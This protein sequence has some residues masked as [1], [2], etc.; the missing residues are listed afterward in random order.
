[1]RLGVNRT[2]S[3]T[4]RAGSETLVTGMEVLPFASL[5]WPAGPAF[6]VVVVVVGVVV[7]VVEPVVLVVLDVV[8]LVEPVVVELDVESVVLDVDV[9]SARGPSGPALPALAK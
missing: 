7:V 4:R 6:V 1:M 9:D 5:T 8:V 2:P 3:M